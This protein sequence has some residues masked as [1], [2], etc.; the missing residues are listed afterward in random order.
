MQVDP[1]FGEMYGPGPHYVTQPDHTP[2]WMY[3]KGQRVR[4][5]D[6]QGIQ[7]GPEHRN[8]VP[9]I[10]WAAANS[11]IDPRSVD[12]SIAVCIEVQSQ[13]GRCA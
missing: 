6:K 11:W 7:V 12:L 1:N 2:V 4:F 10:I 5:F 9:A 3:R 13:I 8:V